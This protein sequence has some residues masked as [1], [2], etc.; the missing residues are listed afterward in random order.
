[1]A[2]ELYDRDFP[3]LRTLG[4]E[5]TSEP[6]DYNC[7]AYAAGDLDRWW[8]PSGRADK[9]WPLPVPQKITVQTFIDVFATLRYSACFDGLLE[10][11]FE[12]V[13][14]YAVG[15]NI[16]KHAA[17]QQQTGKWRS[18]LGPDEDVEHTL[19]GLF[20]PCYGKVIA[21]LRRE[22]HGI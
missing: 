13:A 2:E 22:L 15:D 8:W 20:G 18:K 3:N 11:G 6:A 12:K 7:I 1:M 17:K 5:R 14:L 9:Y 10:S 16:V 21:F 19:D 4:F